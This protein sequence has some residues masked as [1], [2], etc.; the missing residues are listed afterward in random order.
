MERVILTDYDGVCANWAHGFD[1]WMKRH[2]YNPKNPSLYGVSNR[3][4]FDKT[5]AR[6]LTKMFNESADIGWLP[7]H[8]DAIKYIRKL[9]EEHGYVFHC[10]TS[11][12]LEPYA[13][14]LRKQNIHNLF[15]RTV[16]E[17]IVC[18][19]TGADK[20]DALSEYAGSGLYWIEDKAENVEAGIKQGLSGILMAHDYN[21]NYRGCATRVSNWKEIYALITGEYIS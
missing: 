20:D 19:D 2:G 1:R 17:K 18:L 15:G 5:R 3:Y 13:Y 9:H 21:A 11:L 16:F 10:Y 12:S 6:E 7:P 14:E 8:L 4:G